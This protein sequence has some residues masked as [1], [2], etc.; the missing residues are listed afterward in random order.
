LAIGADQPAEAQGLSVDQSS[1]VGGILGSAF[2]ASFGKLDTAVPEQARAYLF[3]ASGEQRVEAR[4]ANSDSGPAREVR[5]DVVAGVLEADAFEEVAVVF[6]EGDTELSERLAGVW[7]QALS[8]GFVDPIGACLD[9][10]AVD[11]ALA[12]RN[13]GGET[14]R[15]S[16]DYENIGCFNSRQGVAWHCGEVPR[17]RSGT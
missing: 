13:R 14:G 7:H 15:P 4:P 5:V 9:D 10:G 1:L 6:L 2:R 3:R 16:T 8:T 12:K 11:A 17:G